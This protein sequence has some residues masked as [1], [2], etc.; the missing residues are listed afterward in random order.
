MQNSLLN[1]LAPAKLNLFLHIVGRRPDGYHLLQTALQ[2]IDHC[3]SLDIFVRLDGKIHRI[4]HI[5]NIPLNADLTIQAAH[6]L[7][8]ASGKYNLGAD[9]KIN[10]QIPLGGGLGGGSSNAATTLIALNYLWKTKFT[11]SKLM[12]LSMHL[13]T[14]VPFFLYGKNAFA[15]GTGTIFTPLKIPK[16]WFVV[17]ECGIQI[18]TKRIF[19]ASQLTKYQK[20]VKIIN[21]PQ[22]IDFMNAN[23]WKNN[24]ESTTTQCF[25]EIN[26]VIHWLKQFGNARMTGS[27]SCI[28]CAFKNEKEADKVLKQVPY[29][30]IG[31]K[32]QALQEHPLAHFL[33]IC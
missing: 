31:W 27:G 23:F 25:P 8:I 10:K 7:Q 32:T 21:Y 18:S 28:F 9:I 6:L 5:P 20:P 3:D 14:D 33:N 30:W 12:Q 13:G 24:L 22:T 11:K 17:I 16:Y 1:C 29:P 2:L 19:F 4:N 26:S 15:E